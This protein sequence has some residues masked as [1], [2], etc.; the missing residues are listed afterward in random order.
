MYHTT[1]DA[2]AELLP[3]YSD[4]YQ[5]VIDENNDHSGDVFDSSLKWS[6]ASK[7]KIYSIRS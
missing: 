6:D 5:N 3:S 4:D 2:T 7:P 1:T